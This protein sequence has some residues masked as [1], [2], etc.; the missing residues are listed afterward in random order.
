MQRRLGL[1]VVVAAVAV[2]SV[3]ATTATIRESS[4]KIEVVTPHY[5]LEVK[6]NAAPSITMRLLR[7][8]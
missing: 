1:C 4:E 2:I 7:A 3:A 8:S 5:Q 6:R